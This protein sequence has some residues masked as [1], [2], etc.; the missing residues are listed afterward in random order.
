MWYKLGQFILKYRLFLLLVLLIAT[1]VMGYFG[2]Q[3]KLS[4][5]FTR[6]IPT[7]NIK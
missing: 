2:S 7:D 6:A 3:V 5:E 1:G 4:Y